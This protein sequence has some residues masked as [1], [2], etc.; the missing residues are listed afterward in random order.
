[1]ADLEELQHDLDRYK[2]AFVEDELK[3]IRGKIN[4]FQ[5]QW[6]MLLAKQKLLDMYES[7]LEEPYSVSVGR[8]DQAVALDGVDVVA[9]FGPFYPEED[10][11]EE[12][13]Y[14]HMVEFVRY[15]DQRKRRQ[16]SG[17][18]AN[19]GGNGGCDICGTSVSHSSY[20]CL[21]RS[22]DRPEGSSSA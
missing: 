2:R 4:I 15:L 3:T 5:Q 22:P 16:Q 21:Y 19:G 20:E 18:A 1:M 12:V 9:L 6:E 17:T 10:W 11:P 7:A 13:P 14:C 8:W